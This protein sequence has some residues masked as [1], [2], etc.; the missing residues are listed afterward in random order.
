MTLMRL[1]IGGAET[2][3]LEL[4]KTLHK[5]GHDI[6]VVSNG[7]VYVKELEE[8]GVK[9]YKVPLHNK[10][11]INGFS[12]FV[13]LWKIIR[14][15]DFKL[16][17]A[18]ARIPAFICG[19]LQKILRFTR[20]KFRLVT[21]AHGQFSVA[22]PFNKLSNWGDKVLAV[23]EDIREYL[24]LNYKVEYKNISMTVNGIDT[25]KFS[26]EVCPRELFDELKLQNDTKKIVCVTRMDKP[27]SIPAHVLI[28][29]AEEIASPV[30]II[31][32]GDGDD[33]DAIQ[34]AAQKV[35]ARKKI[36]HTVGRRTD[37]N[38]FMAAADIVVSVSRAALEAMSTEKP[39]ILAGGQGFLGAFDVCDAA[40]FSAAVQTNFTCRDYGDVTRE[41]LLKSVNEML[42]LPKEKLI[43]MG[44]AGRETVLAGYSLGRMAKDAVEAY[45]DVLSP[46]HAFANIVISGY[47]GYDN[48][49]DDILLQSIVQN[50]RACKPDINLTVLS[51]KPKETRAKFKVGAIYRFNIFKIISH[52]RK[53]NVLITGGG[54]LIQDETSTKSLIYY[55]FII[56]IAQFFSAKN[57]LYAKGIGPLR[58]AGNI[59]RVQ[60]AL[61]NVEMITLRESGSLEVLKELGITKPEIHV[62]ADAAFAL[63]QG[64]C[65]TEKRAPFFCVAIRS[66]KN[67]PP[68][69]EI[70]MARFADFLIE[71][72]GYEAVF[73]PMYPAQDS[74]LS[75]RVLAQMKNPGTLFTPKPGDFSQGRSILGRA[76]FAVCMRLHALIYAMEKGVPSIGLVYSPKIL[77][78]ME[79]MGQPWH[80]PVEEINADGL[81]NFANE[82][83]ANKENISAEIIKSASRLR[84]LA[85][86]NAELCISLISD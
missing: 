78:F 13:A 46:K 84:K 5:M 54:N 27:S 43:E 53:A 79:T 36:I 17:H 40:V 76:E 37:V 72:Y 23:S 85:A 55:L 14:K 32:V 75:R 41:K 48:S 38:K 44:K 26:P 30:E 62:T 28:E 2:H 47:Y 50:L 7:G 35:N 22:F 8:C 45:E 80:M 74:E 59:R 6:H 9:H 66:W 31:L 73:V 39:V 58:R 20:H 10:Q 86:K 83:H 34:L 4:S 82:I 29:I 1:D 68:D 25:E 69:I 18:H 57:M 42:A 16:V 81:I 51:I 71:K 12:S 11:F 67:N 61:A 60:K 21:T 49:G 3:V 52:L 15:N 24:L 64:A 77:Q 70:Q 33:F 56:K 63:P 65:V 19:V